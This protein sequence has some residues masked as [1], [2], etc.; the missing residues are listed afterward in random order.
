MPTN[1]ED[2]IKLGQIEDIDFSDIKTKPTTLAGY[3]ITDSYTQAQSDERFVRYDI[4]QGLT[5]SQ[6]LQARQNIG[7]PEGNFHDP[8]TI[9]T[10]NGLSLSNQVLSLALATTTTAGAMS[11][12]DKV[13]LDGIATNANNYSHPTQG[14]IDTGILTNKQVVSRIQVNSLGHVI[15]VDTRTNLP[16]VDFTSAETITGL[17]T[18]RRA[19][20]NDGSAVQPVLEFEIGSD[21]LYKTWLMNSVNELSA[22]GE[23]NW[24]FRMSENYNNDPVSFDRI[25]FHR[26]GLVVLG[27]RLPSQQLST[28]ILVF[29]T[30]TVSDA[31]PYSTYIK[32]SAL[33][34]NRLIAGQ[35]NLDGLGFLGLNDRIYTPGRVYAKLGYKTSNPNDT[36]LDGFIWKLG[37]AFTSSDDSVNRLIEVSIDGVVYE[38]LARE[39][40]FQPVTPDPVDPDPSV[41]VFI[42]YTIVS[43]DVA[44]DLEIDDAFGTFTETVTAGQTKS[45]NLTRT[46]PGATITIT[47]NN[48]DAEPGITLIVNR[49]TPSFQNLYNATTP[50][51]S[52][53]YLLTP[54]AGQTY[55]VLV[56]LFKADS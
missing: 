47:A 4:A 28:D 56:N 13:K 5:S 11:A 23:V 25:G 42:N 38:I 41:N 30:T 3:G 29:T 27:D 17:K 52:D 31:F 1:T 39:K 55:E 34:E 19:G 37:N 46:N 48:S 43:T 33:L 16:Y 12:A 15:A 51:A 8:V 44:G 26:G 35:S 45:G 22:G 7:V 49:L 32:R 20:P 36:D 2:K 21:N 10:A 6:Q 50:T 53:Q 54:A 40:G 18:I 14:I 24:F 9:G